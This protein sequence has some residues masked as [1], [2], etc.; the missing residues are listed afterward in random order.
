MQT[1]LNSL[2]TV[3]GVVGEG[4]TVA[5]L[6]QA[7]TSFGVTSAHDLPPSRV[8]RTTPSSVPTQI[9][10]LSRFESPMLQMTP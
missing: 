4:S 9:S 1:V 3:P 10:E 7:G 8:R 5:I 2:I 6:A